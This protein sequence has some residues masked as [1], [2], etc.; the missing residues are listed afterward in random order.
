[1][2]SNLLTPWEEA[3]GDVLWALAEGIRVV[4]RANVANTAKT[5]VF[6]ENVGH[7]ETPDTAT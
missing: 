1:M 3:G 6:R 5:N 7:T 4:P 2:A